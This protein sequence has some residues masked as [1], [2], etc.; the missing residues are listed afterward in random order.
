MSN[1]V[2]IVKSLVGQVF[3][4][5]LDGL[6][7]QIFEG[8]RLLQGEQLLTGLGGE[9]TLQLA[10]GELL[11]V[12]QNSNW[13]AGPANS[14][15][16][17]QAPASDLE[18]ALAA[19][20]DPTTDLEA[21]AAG[22][23]TGGGTGGAAGGGHSFVMLDETGQ[24]LEATVGFETA[25]LAFATGELDEEL[26]ELATTDTAAEIDEPGEP[27]INTAPSAQA[28]AFTLNEDGTVS[29][30]VLSNDSD[31]DGDAL[32]ITA[33]DGQAIA[34]GISV[35]VNN[36]TV[37]L[38]NGQLVFTPAANYSGPAN[39][40]YTISD[41]VASST[42]N[43]AGTVTSVNDAPVAVGDSLVASEDTAVT[44]SATDLLGNDSDVDGDTLTI[45]SVT[46]GN[47]GTAVLNADGTVTFTP[48]ANFNGVADFSYT[49]TDGTLTSNTATVTVNVAAVNDAP[50]AVGDSLVASEDTAVTY[51]ATDLLGNDSDVDGDT[52]TIA[53]VTSGNGG[54]AVL[55]ADGTVTFTPNANFNGVADFSYTVTDGTLISNTATVTVNVAAVNDAPVAVDDSLVASEDTAVTYSATDLLGNDSDVDGD[56][57]TIASVTSGN[58]GT[59]VLNAD[60]TVTFTPNANFNGVADFSYTV[61]DGTLISNTATVTVNV[62]AVNDAP[63]AANDG[64]IAVIE[65]TAATGNVLDN[66]SDPENDALSVTQ[67]TVAGDATIYNAG[68]TANIAGV[69]SL[70]INANGS[71]TFT[72]ATNYTGAV[73][74]ATYTVSDGSL[75]NSAELSFANV[76]A[77]ND[78]VVAN[79]DSF[80]VN[81]DGSVSLNLLGNDSAADG[82]LSIQSINGTA[83][84]GGVQ[85]IAVANGVVNVAADGSLTFV[86]AADF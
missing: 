6:K 67:F 81:E 19:G 56:T 9:A 57:L 20:F 21:T 72:P 53:S 83:L 47:G 31:L 30:D 46:S 25:G 85:A 33:V 62:A 16:T 52:L 70:V 32:T 34:E 44:Y 17:A 43:I 22:A 80:S 28:D 18:Q 58:G 64:P 54:T 68:S 23:G 11:S 50:V 76:N 4:V 75:T 73:P 2:A 24:Q 5:S 45:A 12:T 63:V 39:F 38:T 79:D 36:G 13:Q 86:P 69:G 37:T 27:S 66:D 14:V 77:V 35:S 40:S 7:R 51:S 78:P 74:T 26:G 55:N 82:G 59:A 10:N 48:N 15:E 41:G 8:E 29:I 61:T 3:A 84:I 49:V 42:A 65:D 1:I 60:G 71:F